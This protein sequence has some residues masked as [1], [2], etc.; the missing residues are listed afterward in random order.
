MANQVHIGV[1]FNVDDITDFKVHR[2]TLDPFEDWYEEGYANRDANRFLANGTFLMGFH[3]TTP[4]GAEGILRDGPRPSPEL[5]IGFDGR[6]MPPGFWLNSMPFVPYS[7]EQWLPRFTPETDM[8]ILGCIVPVEVARRPVIDTTWPFLQWPVEVDDIK[9]I[10]EISPASF[11]ALRTAETLRD[12][13]EYISDALEGEEL[14]AG[15]Y[16]AQL[17]HEIENLRDELVA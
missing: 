5:A 16:A 7:V 3:L 11:V 6:K 17:L 1:D 8:R 14:P 9:R 15:G 2:L 4:E 13:R 10:V 12:L